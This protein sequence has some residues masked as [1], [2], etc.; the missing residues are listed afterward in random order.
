[1]KYAIFGSVGFL[2]SIWVPTM[3]FH[4]TKSFA[5][6]FAALLTVVGGAFGSIFFAVTAAEAAAKGE[7]P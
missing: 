2:V 3:L 4:D 6:G 5:I 7:K 1:M